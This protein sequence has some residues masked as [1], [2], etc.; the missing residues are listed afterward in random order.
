M[1]GAALRTALDRADRAI[2]TVRRLPPHAAVAR[3]MRRARR[4]EIVGSTALAGSELDAAEVNALLDQERAEGNHRFRDYLLV[5]AYADATDWI[6]SLRA[7]RSGDAAPLL[8]IEELRSINARASADSGVGGGA[9][10]LGNP[11]ARAGIVAPAAWLVARETTTL[12]DRFARG[13]H[14][15]PVALWLA[16]FLARLGRLVPFE[17]ANGRTARLAANLMLRRIDA[18]PLVFEQRERTRYPAAL[19]AAQANEP[20]ALAALV[21][22]AIARVGDRLSAATDADALIPLREL[23]AADYTALAKAAQ[24]GRLRTIVRG[25]R[26]FTTARWIDGYRAETEPRRSPA[27]RPDRQVR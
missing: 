4:A 10:R 2:A 12:L 23:A 15:V 3:E 21:A 14:D 24:R 5:R 20:S 26:Y 16:R 22:G 1:R 27:A 7:H 8:T 17:H 9:W 19:A 13:P 25:G 11:A 18:V 6:A